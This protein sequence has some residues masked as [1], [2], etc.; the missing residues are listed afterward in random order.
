MGKSTR[1]FTCLALVAHFEEFEMRIS[2]KSQ[3]FASFPFLFPPK[4]VG[5]T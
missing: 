1:A 3:E 5:L 4:R 2:A